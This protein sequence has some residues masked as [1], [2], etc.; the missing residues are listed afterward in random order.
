MLAE[1]NMGL[2]VEKLTRKEQHQVFVQQRLDRLDRVV[3]DPTQ[4]EA[5]H[6]RPEG[7]SQAVN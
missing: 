2:D 6:F 1:R 5:V 7:G 4:C 3:V